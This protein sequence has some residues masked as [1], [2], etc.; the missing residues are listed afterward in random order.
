LFDLNVGKFVRKITKENSKIYSLLVIDQ[1]LLC[2]GDDTG[3]F[4]VWDYRVDRG[5]AMDLKECDDYISDL[6]I[7]SNKRI[8]VAASG[9]GTLTA[10]NIRSVIDLNLYKT[11]TIFTI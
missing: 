6:D 11:Y 4:R 8:V 9:E 5:T 2:C 3:R 1:Y 10:F 7:D